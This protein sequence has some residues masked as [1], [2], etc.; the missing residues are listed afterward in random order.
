MPANECWQS[1][2]MWHDGSLDVYSKHIPSHMTFSVYGSLVAMIATGLGGAFPSLLG[3]RY[4]AGTL[5]G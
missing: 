2:S 5:I 4:P 1:V 3:I